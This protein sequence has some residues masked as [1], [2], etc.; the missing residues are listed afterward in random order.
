MADGVRARQSRLPPVPRLVAL[1]HLDPAHVDASSLGLGSS[2]VGRSYSFLGLRPHK[3]YALLLSSGGR[4]RTFEGDLPRSD[5]RDSDRGS[6]GGKGGDADRTSRPPRPARVGA[7][8]P[9]VAGRRGASA[10]PP[11][12]TRH[13]DPEAVSL[14]VVSRDARSATLELKT[15]GFYALTSPGRVRVFVSGFDFPQDPQAPA[16]PSAVPSSTPSSAGGSSSGACARSIRSA[17]PASSRAA[18][19]RSRCRSRA[20]A[21]CAPA[22][23]LSVSSRP[24]HSIE[25]APLLPSVFQGETKSAVVQISPLRFDARRQQIVLARRVLVRLLFTGRETARADGAAAA[26]PGPEERRRELLAR[27]YT[28]SRGLHGARST[29]VPGEGEASPHP[30]C[31]SSA[32][33]R[34]RASTSSPRRIRSARAACSTSTP[35]PRPASTDFSSEIAWELRRAR[36][37][38]PD[39]D[40]LGRVPGAAVIDSP[41]TGSRLVRDGP[42]LPAGA[43]RRTGPVA[44]GRPRLGG[45]AD[46]EL[47]A[48]RGERG[49][50]RRHASSRSSCRGPRSPA[51]P[52]TTT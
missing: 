51:S 49:L 19:A 34:R 35:T 22:A 14:R 9:C 44:V 40:R 27:L 23:V 1:R 4:R 47:L 25:L 6:S 37:G 11:G 30:S 41:P 48:R 28:T 20:T 38:V 3:R 29:P 16:L 12:C 5:L 42:L 17:S 52:S 39:A 24:H 32:R 10:A 18:S 15:G 46:E 21:R 2:P 7:V 43:A 26:G 8:G 36:D 50:A 13:G 33:A 31:V 45:D